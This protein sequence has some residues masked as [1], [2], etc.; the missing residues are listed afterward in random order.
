VHAPLQHSLDEAQLAPLLWQLADEQVPETQSLLQHV[1]LDEQLAPSPAHD[2]WAHVPA[3]HCPPQQSLELWH[4]FPEAWHVGAAQ[5]PAVHVALQ[6]SLD[7]EHACPAERHDS[8]VHTP[9][10]QDSLQ[11]SLY[12]AHDDPPARHLPAGTVV[13][14]P[15]EAPPDASGAKAPPFD[16]LPAHPSARAVANATRPRK[17]HTVHARR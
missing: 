14:P 3:S 17:V 2:G 16:P 9:A 11:Q 13:L 6:Q 8:S 5:L 12:A 7:S 15:E 10:A 1:A 4:D